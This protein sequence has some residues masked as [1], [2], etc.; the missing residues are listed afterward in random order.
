MPKFCPSCRTPI[1]YENALICPNC[2]MRIQPLPNPEEWKNIRNPFFAVVFSFLFVGWGQWYNGQT[3]GGIKF[4]GAMLVFFVFMNIFATI[5]SVLPSAA[6]IVLILFFLMIGIWVYGMYDAY[7]TAERIN[8]KKESFFRKSRLFVLP[9][10]LLVFLIFTVIAAFIFGMAGSTTSP[11]LPITLFPGP[12]QPPPMITIQ[13]YLPQPTP[14][15][16]PRPTFTIQP[17]YPQPTSIPQPI[18]TIIVPT[19]HPQPTYRPQ[20]IPISP[21]PTFTPFHPVPMPTVRPPPIITIKP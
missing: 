17:Y 14:I 20:P 9:V 16:Q 12:I 13:P 6:I 1:Q 11:S 4:L 15:V 10:I 5:T 3:F 21:P 2:G 7:K 8:R 18:R 19:Y